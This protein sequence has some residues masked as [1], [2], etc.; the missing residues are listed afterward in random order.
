MITSDIFDKPISNTFISKTTSIAQKI[1][2]RVIVDW[3]DSRHVDKSGNTNIVTSNYT[4]QDLTT[5]NINSLSTGL[6]S[7][8]RSLTSKEIN[9]NKKAS[10]AFY[11]KPNESINGI[12]RQSYTWA[13]VGAKDVNGNIITANGNWHCMPTNSVNDED[14]EELFEFG[15]WSSNKS[16][17]NTHSTL[18][19]YGMSNNVI[20][21]YTFVARPVNQIKVITSEYYG[22]IKCYNLKIYKNTNTLLLNQD[23]EI[24]D[25]N[26]F[27][28][29]YLD[30]IDYTEINRIVLE[31]YTTKNPQDYARIN[32]LSVLYR[33][34]MSDYVIDAGVNKVRDLHDTSLPI[35]GGGASTADVNFDNSQK[36]FNLFSNSSTY[37]KYMKKDLRVFISGG[38]QIS[39]GYGEISNAVLT[40]NINSSAN[41]ISVSSL[42]A[43]PDDDGSSRYVLIIDG[44]NENRE[45]V[46]G[47]K[48]S[49]QTFALTQRGAYESAAR[50]H[51]SNAIVSFDTYEY[52]PYGIFYV[53]EWQ[54]SSVS[55]A[56]SASLT[57]W[58]KFTNEK[59]ISKGFLL[60]D[61]LTGEA[62]EQLLMK[63]NFPKKDIEY[64]A[65]PKRKYKKQNAILH[66]GF[67]EKIVDRDN[68]TR[69]IANS[70]RARFVEVPSNDLVGLKDIYLDANDTELTTV[71]KALDIK[72]FYTPMLTTKSELIST[73]PGGANVALN[74]TTGSWTKQDG[75]GSVSEYY[76][77]V[78]DGFYTPSTTGNQSIIIEINRGGVRVFLEKQ[79]IINRWYSVESGSNSVV[80]IE[81]DNYYL[82]A[83]NPVELRIE[84]F[85]SSAQTDVPFQLKLKKNAGSIDWI[86]S[87]ETQTAIAFDRIGS[88]SS[89]NYATFNTSTNQWVL[90]SSDTIIKSSR[91][92][93]AIYRG[94]LTI[95]ESSGV[96]SDAESKSVLLTANSY[97]R[98]PYDLSYNVFDS[99]SHTYTGDMSVVCYAKFHNN[100]FTG[101]G[102]FI[103]N[104]N[105]ASPSA[106]FELFYNSTSH[107]LKIVTSSGVEI[108]SSNTAISNSAFTLMTF[109]LKNNNLKYFLNGSLVNT[110]TL[111]G[112]PVSY[113]NKDLTIG[114]RGASFTNAEIAPSSNRILYVDEFA[115]FNKALNNSEVINQY[116]E[117][118]MEKIMVY[119]F[120]FGN[121]STVQGIIDEVTMADLGR[122]YIDERQIAK[123]ENKNKFFESSIAQHANIQQTFSDTAN[124]ID[125][126]YNVQLQTNKVVVK[127]KGTTSNLVGRQGLW[128]A[129]SPTTLGVTKLTSN[130]SN[131]D[132]S[133]FVITTDDPYFEKTGYLK[134][135][136]EI[137]KYSNTT[138]NSFVSLERAQ[139][140]TTAVSHSQNTK[141]R[142]VRVFEIE[143][144]KS[145]AFRIDNPYI[146]NVVDTY[147][148]T[149]EIFRYEPNAYGALLIV[150]ATDNAAVG[151]IVYLEGD[152]PS[153]NSKYFAS[154]AGFPVAF[155]ETKGQVKDKKLM[156]DDNIR[157]Y[158]LK[159]LIIENNFINNI[160]KANIMAQFIINKMSEPVPVLNLNIMPNPRIQL[161]DRI[162]ISS[163]D[164]FDIINGDYWIISADSRFSETPSQSIVIRKVV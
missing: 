51:V 147:P 106:G 50:S 37:G 49:D 164:S 88:K 149:V 40:A 59:T 114:G 140:K 45:Y 57:D 80:T 48:V 131:S 29:H 97:L 71:E 24:P 138:S 118:Q 145:P 161:G 85:T 127:I 72:R 120:I 14:Q 130:I 89:N 96:V 92:N 94:D 4:W 44:N 152:D 158:G 139:F 15:Y 150:A 121:D 20:I 36:D 74:F 109:T 91:R 73:Q 8:S 26:Y 110:V 83:G 117:T 69:T 157:R 146:T 10:T 160:E 163:M 52:V 54:A 154:I 93:N 105:N 156:L 107:G 123:Y 28:T 53:D 27:F 111:S 23:G 19:G 135:D 43:I 68:Q 31:I 112:T 5:E 16:N 78:I 103:S 82:L 153:S 159:E 141:V 39:K 113:A 1:K 46:I 38:W 108:I 137:V 81:S 11:F 132:T 75:S 143:W 86:Y 151:S 148:P 22:Q 104:W 6:L 128:R 42:N 62:V 98:V 162:R 2:P 65:E 56:V 100:A 30:G 21:T 124:I 47:Y 115:I 99:N 67:D 101:T 60:Q 35:A 84:F 18:S 144:D 41:S 76:N 55:M 13:V 33:V 155:T 133:M 9:F 77:G 129:E 17:S 34:D 70:L 119:P 134:I 58:Q 3:L 116:I 64:L 125:A 90:N 66:L 32:E 102:E 61:C 95:G 142:E 7:N 63:V 136:D 79:L 87:S 122:M 12:E 126:S 25:D